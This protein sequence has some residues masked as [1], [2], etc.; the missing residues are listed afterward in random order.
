MRY[1]IIHNRYSKVGGEEGVVEKQCAILRSHGHTV[2]TYIRSYDET[3]LWRFPRI[4]RLFSALYSRQ[5]V[6]DI[7]NIV[8][9]YDPEVA[10][11]HNLYPVISPAI[12]PVLHSR[13][14]RIVMT[15]HNY[16]LFCP[17][18]LCYNKRGICQRCGSSP[19]GELNCLFNKCE[20]TMAG[21]LAFALR[22]AW[23]RIGGY[24]R[25][26]VDRYMALSTFQRDKLIQYAALPAERVDIVPN[27]IDTELMPKPEDTK[28][29]DF[30]GYVGRLS[31]EKGIDLL[32]EVARRMPEVE[33]RVAGERSD[34]FA[35]EQIPSN[36]KLV[37]FLSKQEL[38][39]F[40]TQSRAVILT[41]LCWDN[42]PL[43]VIEAM[44]Y[45]RAVIVPNLAALSEIIG[46]GACGLL[47][48]AGSV[49]QLKQ[50]IS[51]VVGDREMCHRLGE[52]AHRR[53]VEE[54]SAE[55]Y[56]RSLID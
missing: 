17:I 43:S 48:R 20:G 1:L 31:V 18:G 37:G 36:I 16:R 35:I 52:A 46:E 26:N 2:Q 11:V 23:A 4:G 44:Y 7:E 13:G 8:T 51:R 9:K 15:L 38:A 10:I 32:F 6:R 28:Q 21:S 22:G 55:R 5:S 27:C 47:Y 40:Y 50:A 33:F 3:L 42:F 49:E 30:I 14:V 19:M 56:Y 39:T 53:V 29:Q 34:G 24:Y 25:R 54:Y 12:L 45:H 41:S